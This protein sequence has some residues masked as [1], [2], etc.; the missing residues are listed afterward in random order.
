MAYTDFAP[1]M[2]LLSP[3][4]GTRILFILVFVTRHFFFLSFRPSSLM[5]ALFLS[6]LRQSLRGI[7]TVFFFKFACEGM[8]QNG[9]N[10]QRITTIATG[11]AGHSQGGSGFMVACHW[12][13]VVLVL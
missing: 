5:F 1:Y 12:C 13:G 9:R 7:C 8:E 10:I 4:T 6:V 2:H 3:G 11:G